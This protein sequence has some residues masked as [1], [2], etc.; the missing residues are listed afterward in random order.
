[1]RGGGLFLLQIAEPFLTESL[2][3]I[4]DPGCGWASRFQL[5]AEWALWIWIRNILLY[6]EAKLFFGN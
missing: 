1:M 6:E 3:G 5:F 2:F 4:V